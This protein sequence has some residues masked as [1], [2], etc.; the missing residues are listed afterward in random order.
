[1]VVAVV[2]STVVVGLGPATTANAA[3]STIV[4]AAD[5]SG[6]Y[7]NFWFAI[8]NA[9]AGDTVEVKSGTYS[10]S[11]GTDLNVLDKPLTIR[12]DPAPNAVGPGADAPVLADYRFGVPLTL[13]ANASGTTI[14]GIVFEGTY[15]SSGLSLSLAADETLSGVVVRDSEFRGIDRTGKVGID[16]DEI[17]GS[18]DSFVVE[19]VRFAGSGTDGGRFGVQVT[20]GGAAASG[21][22]YRNVAFLDNEFESVGQAVEIQ[23][24]T[25]EGGLSDVVFRGNVVEGALDT[26]DYGFALDTYARNASIS[27]LT[28]ADNDVNVSYTP[29]D[30]TTRDEGHDVT[31]VLVTGN[32]FETR[33]EQAILSVAGEP[34]TPGTMAR[35]AIENNTFTSSGDIRNVLLVTANDGVAVSDLV[36]CNNII[37]STGEADALSVAFSEASGVDISGNEMNG[38]DTGSSGLGIFVDAPD[39]YT[40]LVVE[41]VSIDGNVIDTGGEGLTFHTQ[42][43]A[44]VLRNLSI[45]GNVVTGYNQVAVSLIGSMPNGTF[46]DVAI[47]RNRVRIPTSNVAG[48]NVFGAGEAETKYFPAKPFTFTNVSVTRNDVTAAE[49]AFS[50][51]TRNARSTDAVR[52]DGN[53]LAM[54]ATGTDLPGDPN[55]MTL[56][57]FGTD[58]VDDFD[59]NVTNNTVTGAP[60]YGVS[61]TA[62]VGQTTRSS[63]SVR[64]VGNHLNDSGVAALYLSTAD[65]QYRTRAGNVTVTGNNVTNNTVAFYSD[66]WGTLAATGNYLAGNAVTADGQGAVTTNTAGSALALDVYDP[67]TDGPD[68]VV[69]SCPTVTSGA[70]ESFLQ[71]DDTPPVTSFEVSPTTVAVGEDVSVNASESTDDVAIAGHVWTFGDGT[72]TSGENATHKY[73]AAGD[74]TITLSVT[75]E[76]GNVNSTTRSVTVEAATTTTS[77][78]PT[79][80]SPPP[81]TTS[82]PPTTTSPPPTTT[83]PPPT[84]TTTESSPPPK[85]SPPATQQPT[86]RP[87]TERPTTERPTTERPTTTEPTTTAVPPTATATAA[88]TTTAVPPT[89]TATAAPTTTD[90]ATTAAPPTATGTATAIDD[91]TTAPTT[92]ASTTDGS[93]APTTNASGGT[94]TETPDEGSPGFGV[95]VAVLAVLAALAVGVRRR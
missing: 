51:E 15:A 52:V 66:A 88:P 35:V 6:D 78:P 70:D 27:G 12:G 68:G 25:D 37:N 63:A 26:M 17:D 81:T 29:F 24:G 91:A 31:D 53:R 77:P 13:T 61:V 92:A 55:G 71:G 73:A 79:T 75:D 4:V 57:L 11:G 8:D 23:Q 48:I 47:H 14:E 80:T 83:S 21:T 65:S 33:N 36:I 54:T 42:T 82:P 34:S 74:Y 43:E 62:T 85:W 22:T 7:E 93:A 89:A 64:L 40:G 5:G 20:D 87:T 69:V 50:L 32:D 90:A 1:M 67:A 46:R 76:A 9:S 86:E 84:T 60:T 56:E 58:A 72:T 30:V 45:S 28:I 19:R 94:A 39:Q 41:D 16:G 95:A 49:Q 38:P 59:L 2:A 10:F 18:L 3:S 44:G